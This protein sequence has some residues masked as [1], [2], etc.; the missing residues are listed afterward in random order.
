M[1]GQELAKTFKENSPFLWDRNEI[2]ISNQEEVHKKIA[3]LK[4]DLVIN[5]AA[6]NDVDG[7]EKN[8]AIANQI[9]GYAVGYLAKAINAI[10]GI[11]VHY[12]TD[13]VFKG[14]KKQG[15]L[16]ADIP[17]PQSAYAKSKYLGEQEIIN[18]IKKFYLIRLSRLFG[19]SAK[20]VQ[21]KKSFVD[22]MIELSKTKKKLN[23]VNEELSSPTY[24]PDLARQTKYIIDDKLPFGIYHVTNRGACT[25]AE[26]AKA[27]FAIK[28]LSVTINPVKSSFFPRPA[29]R[30]NYS[31]LINSK[32]PDSRNWQEA[33]NEYLDGI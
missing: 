24:A 14:D 18:N 27:I 23:V 11:L 6:Y 13:Y 2:D 5:A 28:N 7:A 16:E 9:N 4:P 30:P 22:I 1:L 32:L 15:Y 20:S 25:W 12:S 31:Q 33:L 3:G 29:V 19:Q 8:E 21:A 10:G 26:F 17:D